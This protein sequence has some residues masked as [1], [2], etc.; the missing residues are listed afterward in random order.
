MNTT[1]GMAPS[2]RRPL[3]GTGVRRIPGGLKKE[4]IKMATWN[5]RGMKTHGKLA[6]IIME[7]DRL[8]IG[9]L[10]L[11]ETK[12]SGQARHETTEGKILYYSGNDQT[13]DHHGVGVLLSKEISKA[14]SNFVPLSNR[15]ML[16]Q[17]N[18]KP[19]NINV[20]QVYAPTATKHWLKLRSFMVK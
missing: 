6:N 17:L 3:N 20:I 4:K 10:G 19:V 11:S 12:W 7:M 9:I 5:V 18:A 2:L 15:A 14:V 8:Q 16:I 1:Q 13:S